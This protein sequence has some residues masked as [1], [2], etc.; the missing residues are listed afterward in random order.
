MASPNKKQKVVDTCPRNGPD[1]QQPTP[2]PTT[3]TTDDDQYHRGPSCH[4][5]LQ[6]DLDPE[7]T[8]TCEDCLETYC[9]VCPVMY[10]CQTCDRHL[11]VEC[12]IVNWCHHCELA[13]CSTCT[14]SLR[15]DGCYRMLCDLCF[16][17]HPRP[18]F[19]DFLL[20]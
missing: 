17:S 8:L 3:E 2:K 14:V 13:Q 12:D 19:D 5:C 7:A 4:R 15:C 6:S 1:Q 11:C 18:C 16:A 20:N 10:Y 9:R